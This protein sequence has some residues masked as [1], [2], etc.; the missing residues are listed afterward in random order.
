MGQLGWLFATGTKKTMALTGFTQ[1]IWGTWAIITSWRILRTFGIFSSLFFSCYLH[2]IHTWLIDILWK[3]KKKKKTSR[4]NKN[5]ICDVTA[6]Y[7]QSDKIQLNIAEEHRGTAMT[8]EKSTWMIIVKMILK[9][10]HGR[11]NTNDIRIVF[12]RRP[13][14]VMHVNTW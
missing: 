6:G 9:S 12:A 7:T 2:N 4:E 8:N 5:S 1:L 3:K 13:V 14:K 10:S 11:R